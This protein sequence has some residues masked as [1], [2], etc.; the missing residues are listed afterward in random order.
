MKNLKYCQICLPITT[1]S[2]IEAQ[3]IEEKGSK[4]LN[5]PDF[6]EPEFFLKIIIFDVAIGIVK[7][8]FAILSGDI[9]MSPFF[10]VKFNSIREKRN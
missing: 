8:I 10:F 6:I 4:K 3:I 9:V 7:S 5:N 1:D 2:R